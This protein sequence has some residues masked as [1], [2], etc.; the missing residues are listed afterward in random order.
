MAK[1]LRAIKAN[2]GIRAEYRRRLQKLVADM[3]G[4]VLW[5]VR[6]AYRKQESRIAQDASPW[7]ALSS[8]LS[9][10]YRYWM[11]RWTR[12]AQKIADDMVNKTRRRTRASFLSAFR[13][14][15]MTVK[16]KSTRAMNDVVGALIAENVSLIKSIPQRYFDDV[17]ALVQ[18]HASMGKDLKSLEEELVSRYDVTQK[19]AKFIA[20]DQSDKASEAIKRTECSDL[21]IT[22]G[23]WVHVPGT[24]TARATHMRMNGK[25]FKLDEG[26]YDADVGKKV[27]TGQ[28]PGCRCTYRAVIPDLGE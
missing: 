21:G 1:V 2:P 9:A 6:A 12:R 25:R 26:L 17:T 10:L 27:L 16:M 18:R 7:A 20:R 24:K 23:I 22:E 14:A 8:V 19:R 4:S 28:L 13:N 5:W 11:N 3:H 15:N